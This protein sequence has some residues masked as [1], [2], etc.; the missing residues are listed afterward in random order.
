MILIL[1][2]EQFAHTKYICMKQTIVPPIVSSVDRH[3][4]AATLQNMFDLGM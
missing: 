1:T 4:Q 2:N 3:F